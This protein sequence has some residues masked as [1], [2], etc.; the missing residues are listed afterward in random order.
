MIKHKY[1]DE[2]FKLWFIFGENKKEG[3]VDISDG[4]T[5]IITNV[6]KKEAL[7]LLKWRDALQEVLYMLI[8]GYEVF[9]VDSYDK[10]C[11][12]EE[13]CEEKLRSRR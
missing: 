4:D 3:T 12:A 2:A 6:S 11:E 10:L 13:F 5:D 8:D 1:V 9:G 7:R